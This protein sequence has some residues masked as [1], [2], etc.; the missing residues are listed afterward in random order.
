MNPRKEELLSALQF[1]E[2]RAQT[3]LEGCGKRP[4]S[5]EYVL[6]IVR[7]IRDRASEVLQ[8]VSDEEG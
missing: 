6:E 4:W 7:E 2:A 8:A 3:A 5:S 1:V